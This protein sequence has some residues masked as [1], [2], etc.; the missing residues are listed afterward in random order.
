MDSGSEVSTLS[1]LCVKEKLSKRDSDIID[2]TGWIHIKA[3]NSLNIPY[4]GYLEP[5]MNIQGHKCLLGTLQM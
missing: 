4:I 5:D 2:A 1:E 3:A